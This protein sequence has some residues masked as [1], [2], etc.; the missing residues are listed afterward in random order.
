MELRHLRYFVTVADELSFSRAAALLHTAQPSLSQQIKSLEDELG[1]RLLNRSNR[2][3]ELTEAGAVFLAEA[4]VI[5]AQTGRAISRTRNVAARKEW[6]VS[7][8][9][10]PA[11][12]VRMFPLLLPELK[13][14]AP[15]LDVQLHS[16]P[17]LQQEAAL[18]AEEIDV[19]FMR[20]PVHSAELTSE[21]VL[22]EPLVVLLPS[23]HPLAKLPRIAPDKLNDQ[24]FVG[25]DPR[26]SGKLHDLVE[27]YFAAHGVRRNVVQLASN[28]LLNL[29]LVAMGL[30]YSLL[31][32]YVSAMTSD[33]V[34]CR[35]LDGAS[36]LIDLLMVYRSANRSSALDHLVASVRTFASR[37]FR[38]RARNE[39]APG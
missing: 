8:G 20:E 22:T 7:I 5:L 3:V 1:V 10:V 23:A 14:S 33:L 16:L 26:F 39:G 32:A 17:T 35:P 29:N 2:T 31:P 19:A 28:V 18:L 30:G 15:Q 34:C 25:S 21:I 36:P 6:I 11:A 13:V 27:T 38:D 37:P 24:H 12:E 4:R 9:F